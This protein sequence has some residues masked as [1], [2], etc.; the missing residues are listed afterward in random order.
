[1][2]DYY[3]ILRIMCMLKDKGKLKVRLSHLGP[4]CKAPPVIRIEDVC[5]SF[6]CKANVKPIN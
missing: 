3:K 2:T 6:G 4:S 1:M 5:F